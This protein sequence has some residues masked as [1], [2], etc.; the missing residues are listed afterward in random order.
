MNSKL[1][2][3]TS[4]TRFDRDFVDAI[5]N[6]FPVMQVDECIEGTHPEMRVHGWRFH[7][8][9][10]FVASTQFGATHYCCNSTPA[11]SE[12]LIAVEWMLTAN[13]A[14][15][16]GWWGEHGDFYSFPEFDG[17][18]VC[19]YVTPIQAAWWMQKYAWMCTPPTPRT[20]KLMQP[21]FT[22][23]DDD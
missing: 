23:D 21:A 12:N 8:A 2:T 13:D 9:S 1:V 17:K 11:R 10:G 4:I 5:R 7:F 14:E 15:I 3:L 16:A 18:D 22:V 20:L 19:G 6:L